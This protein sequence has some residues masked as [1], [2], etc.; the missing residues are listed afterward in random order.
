VAGPGS[1]TG[2]GSVTNCAFTRGVGAVADESSG[3]TGAA[4]AA[5]F[6]IGAIATASSTR[7]T[8]PG[9]G[10]ESYRS[11]HSTGGRNVGVIRAATADTTGPHFRSGSGVRGARGAGAS[12]S[13][14]V[15][16]ERG[17]PSWAG[18]MNVGVAG[19]D[20]NAGT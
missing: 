18:G 11:G 14:I 15:A 20:A 16:G 17:P 7:D 6:G 5:S 1:V 2:D 4:G 12:A 8:R 10:T 19:R 9:A 3:G 13:G